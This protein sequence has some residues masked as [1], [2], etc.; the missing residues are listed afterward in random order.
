MAGDVQ[1]LD[2]L[3]SMEGFG[4]ALKTGADRAAKDAGKSAGLAWAKNF[5]DAAS[6][7]A[8]AK[9]VTELERAAKTAQRVV[10]TET[11]NIAKARA[12]QRDAAARV[13]DAEGRLVKARESG[14]TSKVEAAELRLEGARERS[15]ATS[16]KVE[17]AEGALR[18]AYQE[19]RDTLGRLDE[20]Q[21][22]NRTETGKTE[23]A[24][25]KLRG[26]FKKSDDAAGDAEG[27]L[28]KVVTQLA[29]AAGAAATFAAAW[30]GAMDLS[31]SEATLE[32]SLGLSAEQAEIA[33]DV[34][35]GLF[36]DSYG[37]SMG[38]VTGAVEAVMSSI[39][40]MREGT[41]EDIYAMSERALA[42]AD[43]MG[44][45]VE[46]STRSAAQ[47]I[48][49]GLAADGVEAFDLLGAALQQ[50]PSALRGEVLAASD[51][52]STFF[53][54]LGLDGPEA[55]GLLVSASE[56]GQYGI[57][58]MG[59]ALKELTIRSTDMSSTSVEAYEAA[60]L[61]A[62]DMS[63]RFL[64]G[65]E[66]ANAALGELVD[67]LLG[68][69]DPTDRA[70]AA[71]A[72]FGTPLEDLGTEGIPEFL[73]SLSGA[74]SALSDFAGTSGEVTD[75]ASKTVDP[76]EGV[77][78][79]FMGVLAEG[80]QPLV[81]PL[82]AV[83]SWATENPGLMQ[84]VAIALGVFAGALGVAAV[85][86][87]AMNSAMLA[88]PITWIILGIVAI[89]AAVVA[90]VK[91]WDSVS[92]WLMDTLGPVADWFVGAWNW[93]LEAGQAAWEGI[94]TAAQWAWE[95]VLSPVFTAV[96]DVITNV[97]GPAMTWLWEN[98][99]VPAWDGIKW[100]FEVAWNVIKL[101]LDAMK[102]YFEKVIAPVATWLWEKV[103]QPAWDGI[104][105]GVTW[106]WDEVVKPVFDSLSGFVEDVVA[107]GI[108]RGVEIV[109]GIWDGLMSLF[110]A[111]INWV[112]ETVWNNGIVTVF[113]NVAKAIGS[114]AR[115][116]Q[117]SLIGAPSSS[118][119]GASRAPAGVGARAFARGGYA[120]PGWALVGEEGPELVN[121]TSPG[122]VYTAVETAHALAHGEDLSPELSRR[123]AGA[124]P[125]QALAPMG[126]NIVQR[127]G[128][129]IGSAVSSAASAVTSWVRGGLASAAGL[130]LDPVKA[131]IGNTVSTWGTF[132][133]L[134]GGAATRQIDNLL[135][136][137]RGKDEAATGPGGIGGPP[138]G[139][140]G[141]VRPSRGP[142]TSRFGPRW[143]GTH[144]GIDI[145]GGGPTFAMHDGV[146]YR[147][148]SGILAGRTG[149]GIGIDHGGGTF[150]YYGHNPI[151]GIQV[152]PGQ[153][154]TAGQHIG[155][156]GATGNVTGIH[157]HAELHRG[158]WGRAVNPESLG[159]FDS[160]GYLQPGALGMNLSNAPEPVLTGQQ[161]DDIHT[162]AMRGATAGR[163]HPDDITALART[164]A[165]EL[166]LTLGPIADGYRDLRDTTD[167]A[168]RRSRMG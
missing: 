11:Q 159:V 18:A 70:N 113:E 1:W 34:A 85:A 119:S 30:G 141:W 55:V 56:D 8:E 39:K 130:V 120:A 6:T 52:Y 142:V 131:L 79:A 80:V 68:I 91:N 59:D 62:E 124:S 114:D 162:L 28:K 135:E 100:A 86:Q 128:S 58:K 116:P 84:G 65:G 5:D 29:L 78:R 89:G 22:D 36:A 96:D 63:A 123:A 93:M 150:T 77:K 106:M 33:G 165:S 69:E 37:E 73:S 155:Y 64:A 42:F 156:Q 31:A 74:D 10:D 105:A 19:Q 109:K 152:Q 104:S 26:A 161:W 140:D 67:G 20:A 53:A 144:A 17:S 129:A 13:L 71:I 99:F 92:A 132:G 97:V 118:G 149:L 90:L 38:D 125:S 46:E 147:T 4:K 145:A 101:G 148:G 133:E 160:G 75:A 88:S 66:D 72:L 14:D 32:A 23:G 48:N 143:G 154:V 24:W 146:V 40:G 137:I 35:G 107:P 98:V 61:S 9:R 44:A 45:D 60:G 15:R 16:L 2:V 110:R 164:M 49:Q 83:A 117:A 139:M 167:G 7:D 81:E 134:T 122:R 94:K 76:I 136:W 127:V 51:E 151:G 168:R 95:N 157:L 21:R 12:A 153:K 57:D 54:Q 121:F 103:F 82:Q 126:D 112:L 41:E 102:L 111:P 47:L 138:P 158:G 163:M 166:G 43:I 50:V 115:L 108:A 27:S 3:P 87:W 25:D